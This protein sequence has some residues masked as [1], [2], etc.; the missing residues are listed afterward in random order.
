[1][2]RS[3]YPSTR[4]RRQ[5]ASRKK[6]E[7]AALLIVLFVLMMATGTAVFALQSTQFEQRAAGS[8]QQAMRT[9]F[10]AE[11]ATVSLLALCFQL[12]AEGCADLKAA[13]NNVEATVRERYGLP[14]YGILE[15]V[16]SLSASDLPTESFPTS[17]VPSDSALAGG[18]TASAFRPSFTTVMEKW[19]V[20]NPGETRPRFRLI[21]STYGQLTY[22]A[23]NDGTSDEV[24]KRGAGELRDAHE[25]ISATRAFFDVR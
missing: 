21:V 24:A 18:G 7:G 8:L 14:D 19:D 16:Y 12:S 13:P 1:M 5:R 23:N 3:S 25:S 22:D 20:P 11:A 6:R 10:V 15:K 9:K 2:N 17:V 4:L